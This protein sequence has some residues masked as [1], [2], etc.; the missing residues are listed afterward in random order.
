[1]NKFLN[2]LII[3]TLVFFF[4]IKIY[5]NIDSY[6]SK[7]DYSRLN[8]L[9]QYSQYALNPNNRL[10]VMQDWDLYAYAGYT[11][12]TTGKIDS[13]NIEHP[14]LGK[15]LYGISILLFNNASILQ[16]PFAIIFL[17]LSFHLAKIFLSSALFSYLIVFLLINESLFSIQLRY[18]LL[19]LM[20]I[21]FI[22]LFIYLISKKS[23]NKLNGIFLGFYLGI[24]A[25]IKFP[26]TAIILSFSY[27]IYLLINHRFKSIISNIKVIFLGILIFLFSYL[28]LFINKGVNGFIQLQIHALR[29]H[30]SHVPE[31]PPF[32]PLKVMILNQWPVWWDKINP[33]WKTQEWNLFWPF[34]AIAICLSPIVYWQNKNDLKKLS[35]FFL[36][37]WVYFVFINTRLFFP[38]Y[39]LLILPQAYIL[40]FWE[41][42]IILKKF[43]INLESL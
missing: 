17:Y 38:G 2:T 1:M 27:L 12:L 10:Y 33:I 4:I 7:F 14:P 8:N 29:I 41:I 34:L 20:E 21:D 15:Y 36:F 43:N 37:T 42:K 30:L 28:P 9:Y 40:L 25:S 26:V 22:L 24:V 3:I 5:Q 18:S 23:T 32:A 16:I 31:Y 19:D 35:L 11:Y 13:I 6:A 39:L